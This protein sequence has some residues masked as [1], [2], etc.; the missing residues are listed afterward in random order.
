LA[1]PTGFELETIK[2]TDEV[3]EPDVIDIST[4]KLRER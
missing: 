1:S 4:L 3:E 2:S